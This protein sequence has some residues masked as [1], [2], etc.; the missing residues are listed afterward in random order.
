MTAALE[1]SHQ[2]TTFQNGVVSEQG[3]DATKHIKV[4]WPAKLEVPPPF[5]PACRVPPGSRGTV[6]SPLLLNFYVDDGILVEVMWKNLVDTVVYVGIGY[7]Y[8][9]HDNFFTDREARGVATV[10]AICI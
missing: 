3:R 2:H 1:Y 7:G 10:A 8:G 6:S 4:L 9:K 5:P